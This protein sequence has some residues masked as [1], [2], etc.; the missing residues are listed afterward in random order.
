MRSCSSTASC[1]TSGCKQVVTLRFTLT[2]IPLVQ[3]P[4]KFGGSSVSTISGSMRRTNAGS[5]TGLK[6]PHLYESLL[7]LSCVTVLLASTR[8]S[9]TPGSC[10]PATKSCL[11]R[12]NERKHRFFYSPIFP[13]FSLADVNGRYIEKKPGVRWNVG[14]SKSLPLKLQNLQNPEIGVSEI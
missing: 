12:A 3:A 11:L 8:H 6:P 10:A 14:Q 7:A 2:I 4:T 1:G 9:V 13:R 5:T